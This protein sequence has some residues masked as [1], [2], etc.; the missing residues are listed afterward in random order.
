MKKDLVVVRKDHELVEANKLLPQSKSSMW[1]RPLLVWFKKDP[2]IA[3]YAKV[4]NGH[5][6]TA[7]IEFLMHDGSYHLSPFTF[8]DLVMKAIAGAG[9]DIVWHSDPDNTWNNLLWEP[10]SIKKAV[11]SKTIMEWGVSLGQYQASMA[12]KEFK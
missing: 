1:N 11:T 12:R 4:G 8:K 7:K 3:K 5:T 9:D 2:I 10:Q 6:E